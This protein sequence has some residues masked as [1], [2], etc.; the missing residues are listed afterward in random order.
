MT[1]EG[2]YIHKLILKAELDPETNGIIEQFPEIKQLVV[3]RVAKLDPVHFSKIIGL[4]LMPT[5]K[6]GITI[7]A[8]GIIEYFEYKADSES[9]TETIGHSDKFPIDDM[10]YKRS[11]VFYN[12]PQDKIISHFFD[13]SDGSLTFSGSRNGLRKLLVNF[14]YTDD[15]SELLKTDM[16]WMNQAELLAELNFNEGF[17]PLQIEGNSNWMLYSNSFYND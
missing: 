10:I 14:T 15:C 12:E 5:E 8:D 4:Y 1:I 9:W 6:Y 11:S 13:R 16:A 17:V 3:T 2:E 7:N